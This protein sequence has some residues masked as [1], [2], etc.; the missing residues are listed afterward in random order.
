MKTEEKYKKKEKEKENEKE[1]EKEEPKSKPKMELVKKILKN[2]PDFRK[3]EESTDDLIKKEEEMGLPDIL[4]KFFRNL[5]YA[6]KKEVI[7]KRFNS[8]EVDSISTELENYILFKLYDK[9]YPSKSSKEDIKFYKKC[10]RLNFIR[11]ENIITD[12]NI[13]NENLWK[14]SIDYIN[15]INNKYTPQDKI[16]TIQKAFNILQNSISF[17]SGKK[18]LGV[19]DTIKPLIYVIIKSKPTNID[20]NYNFS[21]MFLSESLAKSQYGILLT[22]IFMIIRIVKEMK[23]NDLIGVTEE[24]FGKDEDI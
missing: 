23:F 12:K 20:S 16:K 24:E 5:K 18:E 6:V 4:K 13:Y 3:L 21:Q 11:P 19:D 22:Q 7:I 17:C 15:E 2:I 14:I 8:D 1:V 10:C 9:I